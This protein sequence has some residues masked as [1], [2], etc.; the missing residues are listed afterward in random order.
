[1]LARDHQENRPVGSWRQRWEGNMEILVYFQVIGFQVDLLF[2]DKMQRLAFL[3]TVIRP[4][5]LQQWTVS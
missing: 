3:K 5:G 4:I 1:M 2:K